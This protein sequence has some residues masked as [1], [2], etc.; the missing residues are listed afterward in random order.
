MSALYACRQVWPL[1]TLQ[2]FDFGKWAHHRSILKYWRE[3]LTI[4]TSHTLRSCI[5]PCIWVFVISLVVGV[6][7]E[8]SKQGFLPTWLQI[9]H[10]D[11]GAVN[12]YTFSILL[13]R[14]GVLGSDS[15]LLSSDAL[16]HA[17]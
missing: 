5:I 8:M 11:T 6:N 1:I 4:P 7:Q 13:K 2:V 9:Q 16:S 10:L 12:L 17:G 15:G 14:F 3:T